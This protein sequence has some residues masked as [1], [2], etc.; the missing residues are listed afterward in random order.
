MEGMSS[1]GDRAE[2]WDNSKIKTQHQAMKL[3]SLNVE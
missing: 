1:V 3:S 2:A